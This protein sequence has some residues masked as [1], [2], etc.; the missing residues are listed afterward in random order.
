M[1]R[2]GLTD[3]VSNDMNIT[4]TDAKLA[5]DSVVA[6]IVSALNKT[7]KVTVIGLGTF[8]TLKRTARTIMNPKT[9]E[10]VDI[11]ERVVVKFKASKMLKKLLN[12]AK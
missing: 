1:N 5:V 12:E 6:G 8:Y 7:E 3:Y 2:K 9:G 11:S 4:K 10:Q